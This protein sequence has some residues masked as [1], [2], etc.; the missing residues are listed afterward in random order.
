MVQATDAAGNVVA[1][2]LYQ[3]LSSTMSTPSSLSITPANVNMVVGQSKSFTVIDNQGQVRSDAT[4]TPDAADAQDVQMAADGSGLLTAAQPGTVTLT[5]SV[6]GVQATATV[7]IYAGTSLPA[8][9][10]SWTFSPPGGS[11]VVS[12][13]PAVPSAS[14]VDVFTLD[15]AGMLRALTSEGSAVWGY[16]VPLN[17]MYAGSYKMVPDFKGGVVINGGGGGLT[18]LD[19]VT[20]IPTVNYTYSVPN[21]Y[22]YKPLAMHPDGTVF[23]IDPINPTA[24]IGIDPVSGPK[25]SI[26]IPWGSRAS[27]VTG[28]QNCGYGG[29]WDVVPSTS[30]SLVV[31]GDGYAYL[32]FIQWS[33]NGNWGYYSTAVRYQ[34]I[35]YNAGVYDCLLS[36]QSQQTLQVLRVSSSG[37]SSIISVAKGNRGVSTAMSYYPD[38]WDIVTT[39]TRSGAFPNA[40]G[41]I[42]TELDGTVELWWGDSESGYNAYLNTCWALT[43]SECAYPNNTSV[44]IPA[45]YSAHITTL[46]N[47]EAADEIVTRPSTWQAPI[48]QGGNGTFVSNDGAG[49][50]VAYSRSGA[51]AWNVPKG[52]APWNPTYIDINGNVIAQSTLGS[53]CS[54]G[55]IDS[56]GS[57]TMGLNVGGQVVNFPCSSLSWTDSQY[58]VSTNTGT[59]LAFNGGPDGSAPTVTLATSHMST[60][61][62]NNNQVL[63]PAYP[64]LDPATSAVMYGSLQHLISTLS[65]SS[66]GGSSGTAQTKLFNKLIFP[67]TGTAIDANGNPATTSGF[68]RY[69]TSR[70][71]L[72]LD[73]TSSQLDFSDAECGNGFDIMTFWGFYLNSTHKSAGCGAGTVAQYFANK[74]NQASAITVTPSYPL[75]VFF[76]PPAALSDPWE[77]LIFHEGLHGYTG[78]YDA[79]IMSDLGYDYGTQPSSMITQYIQTNVIVPCSSQTQ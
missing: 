20:G 66:C 48:L 47:G 79:D 28:D 32:P 58:G 19:A 13:V 67:A 50:L 63:S 31:A 69:L 4:W 22:G 34:G 30:L 77:A 75:I 62:V 73:G 23:A 6:Q 9:T 42:V 33:A 3:T 21:L 14:G 38:G 70:R 78:R 11:T 29:T 53:T 5:A 57:L 51:Q 41:S 15:T 18:R 2:P 46:T 49:G 26:P 56:S 45:S 72:F 35:S 24:I 55:T 43:S 59:L 76:D 52:T 40:P 65:G 17:G 8:G 36:G 54:T 68:V 12:S 64:P 60:V 27:N 16:Q 1:T 25:F 44:A 10:P 61:S 37:D 7:T 74:T 39:D 71:P